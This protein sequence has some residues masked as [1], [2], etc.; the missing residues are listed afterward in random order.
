MEILLPFS[1]QESHPYLEEIQRCSRNNFIFC[2]IEDCVNFSS[3]IINIHWPEA[4]F[5]WLEPTEK[6]LHDLKLWFEEIR[7]S[8]H[9]VY[10]KHDLFRNKGNTGN[11]KK[12]F[13]IVEENTDTFIHL[14]EYSKDVYMKRFPMVKHHT[15]FHP[16]ITCTFQNIDKKAARKLLNIDS[17]SIVFIVPGNIRMDKEKEMIL[18]AFKKVRERNKVLICINMRNELKFD[19]PGRVRL[20]KIVDVQKIIKSRFQSS[21]QPPKFLFNYYPIS[22]KELN[23]KMLASDIVLI[24]RI[25]ILNSGIAFLAASF[26]KITVGPE[27]G[28]LTEFLK[29][30]NLPIFNPHSTSSV[31]KALEKGIEI[32]RSGN[33]K[34]KNMEKYDP[35]FVAA[36]YDRIF[37]EIIH[38]EA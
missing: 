37:S 23:I 4:F 33:F 26:R 17:E 14:G 2:K 16:L 22:E 11:F 5:D 1:Q 8:K 15:I 29:E 18:K 7:K 6:Q 28:N 31:S 25:N 9:I 10:T 32:F 36:E 20:K 30:Q 35:E 12:L 13:A 21:H 3:R 24:P 34:W 27:T 38:Y 19:F